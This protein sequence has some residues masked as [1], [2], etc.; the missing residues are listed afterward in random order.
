MACVDA[1]LLAIEDLHAA[2]GDG[3][4]LQGVDL[5]VGR[6]ELH[7]IMGPN[8]SGKSTLAGVLLGNPAYTV[9]TGRVRYL[10]EDITHWSPDV[11]GKAGIFL[12]FQYPEEIP[13]VSVAQF[14]RQAVAARRGGEVSVLEVR[15][16]LREWL[17]RLGMDPSF[18][19]R[20]L[21]EGFS[22]GERKRNEILQMALLEPELAVLD[23]TDSGLDIDGL[24][25]VARGVQEVRAARPGL[26][27]IVVT[28]YAKLLEL[29]VPD[30][31]HVLVGGRIAESGGPE[32]ANRLEREGYEA[33]RR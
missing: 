25:V 11:R 12:A 6:G 8:G 14:L 21:N 9:T 23:E 2:A 33:W 15:V 5:E 26:G 30:R 19:E 18:A 27:V 17:N 31:V 22:G 20:H 32:L 1:P 10:G 4:I 29:L 16:Q 24:R 13:G 7:A 28:H 3:E